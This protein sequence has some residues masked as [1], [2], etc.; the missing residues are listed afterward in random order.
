MIPCDASCKI[1]CLIAP[2]FVPP[3]ASRD[4]VH[5]SADSIALDP[6]PS[7]SHS[8]RTDLNARVFAFAMHALIVVSTHTA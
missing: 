4:S 6:R 7:L 1:C 2:K 8:A 5:V 3:M